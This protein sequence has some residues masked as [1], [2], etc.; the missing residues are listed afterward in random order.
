MHPDGLHTFIRR[1]Q[2]FL[3]PSSCF[4]GLLF[5][6]DA[7]DCHQMS[8]LFGLSLRDIGQSQLSSCPVDCGIENAVVDDVNVCVWVRL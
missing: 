2:E 1:V 5:V 7:V 6:D 3:C 4:S 8:I